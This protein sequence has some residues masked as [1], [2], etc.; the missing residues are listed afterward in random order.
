MKNLFFCFLFLSCIN[1]ID[2]PADGKKEEAELKLV[3][4]FE[5]ID[6]SI[7]VSTVATAPTII[8]DSQVLSYI[9]GSVTSII[10]ENGNLQWRYE[11]PDVSR[12]RLNQLLYDDNAIYLKHP[13]DSTAVSLNLEKG[14]INWQL[15]INEGDFFDF[16]SDIMS[17]TKLYLT[18]N[19][20]EL[21]EVSK[22][23]EFIRKIQ[24]EY[25]MRSGQ[26]VQGDLI[27]ALPYRDTDLSRYAFGQLLRY[28][29]K[30]DTIKWKYETNNGGYYTSPILLENEIIYAGT[31]EGP[32]EFIALNAN[33]GQVLWQIQDLGSWAYTLN[34]NAIF[35]NDGADLVALRKINGQQLWRTKFPGGGFS[36]TNIA[37]MDGYVYHSHSGSFF[38]LDANT[39]EIVYSTVLPDQSFA[40]NVSAG[41][42]KVF[43]Q[44]DFNL[45]CFEG[46]VKDE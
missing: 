15:T 17:D 4:G 27:I 13:D 3:W 29:L 10:T 20:Q 25:S 36:S 38:V 42:G 30:T 7:S 18:G 35:I 24:L 2:N 1:C 16:R 44:S 32:G 14:T 33:T 45:Y 46:W 34:E 5:F 43:V 23:G 9:D 8:N 31:T 11:L 21:Y 22:Q 28:D 39:G 26:Y 37:Y 19:D 12:P 40:G 41:F 6:Q